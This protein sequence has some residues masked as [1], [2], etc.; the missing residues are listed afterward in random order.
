[1]ITVL[2][3]VKDHFARP[4]APKSDLLCTFQ[5]N[6]P[7]FVFWK[8]LKIFVFLDIDFL[9]LLLAL[10][11]RRPPAL[12]PP[13]KKDFLRPSWKVTSYFSQA[14]HIFYSSHTSCSK[15]AITRTI[16]IVCGRQ[17]TNRTAFFKAHLSRGVPGLSGI[18]FDGFL[19]IY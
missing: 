3:F 15:T 17:T 16:S 5:F 7:S 1:M 9:G 4:P 14:L 2:E 13:P 12:T 8:C 19:T 11:S 6:F 10:G 18:V